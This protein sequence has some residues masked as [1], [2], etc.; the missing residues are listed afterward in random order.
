MDLEKE[1]RVTFIFKT[2]Y[3]IIKLSKMQLME[4]DSGIYFFHN[5]TGNAIQL[6]T[7]SSVGVA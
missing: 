4:D 1:K 2:C 7:F 6:K 3:Y 5:Y